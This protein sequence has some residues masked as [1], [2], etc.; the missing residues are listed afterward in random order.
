MGRTKIRG[1][2]LAGVRIAI[3]APSWFDWNWPDA[4]AASSCLV[5]DPDVYLALRLADSTP[6]SL[7]STRGSAR[8]ARGCE[9]GRSGDGWVITVHGKDSCQRVAHF[10]A[11]F[12]YGEIA[13]SPRSVA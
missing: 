5:P 1:I 7:A 11:S 13:M 3:E 9:V 10:D 8:I 2:E 6:A 12:R 4:F